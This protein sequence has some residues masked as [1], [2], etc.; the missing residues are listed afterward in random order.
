MDGLG[1]EWRVMMDGLVGIGLSVEGFCH[2][3]LDGVPFGAIW[4]LVTK[5]ALPSLTG[6]SVERQHHGHEQWIGK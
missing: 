2:R 3:I 6:L 1:I 5:C 4:V